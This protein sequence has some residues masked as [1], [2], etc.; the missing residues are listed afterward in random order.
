MKGGGI[1][2]IDLEMHLDGRNKGPLVVLIDECSKSPLFSCGGEL[3]EDN[4]HMRA[5]GDGNEDICARIA[6]NK[7]NVEGFVKEK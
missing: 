7:M 5:N 3:S 1:I 4:E 2:R 6:N